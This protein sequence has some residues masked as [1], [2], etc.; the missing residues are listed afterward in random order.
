M[1][2]DT[3]YSNIQTKE[4]PCSPWQCGWDWVGGAWTVNFNTCGS[5]CS[6]AQP[7]YDGVESGSAE[8]PCL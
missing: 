3:I 4:N 8:T 2:E 6:C 5:G 7:D 1:G